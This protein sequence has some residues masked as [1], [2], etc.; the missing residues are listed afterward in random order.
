MPHLQV[1]QLLDLSWDRYTKFCALYETA[2]KNLN[3]R[4]SLV[5]AAMEPFVPK[6]L[7]GP[8]AVAAVAAELRAAH[9]AELKAAKESMEVD[10]SERLAAAKLAAEEETR[11]AVEKGVE[12]AV[13]KQEKLFKQELELW[14]NVSGYG[15][16]S[17]H[18]M[19]AWRDYVAQVGRLRDT[20]YGT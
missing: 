17:G 1:Y 8:Q 20:G 3:F 14:R 9:A 18:K 4:E 5:A 13:K 11:D 6:L 12:A 10:C 15:S 7:A 16:K 19:Q 2:A